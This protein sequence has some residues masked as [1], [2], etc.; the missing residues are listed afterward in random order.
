[1][2]E[3]PE[4][5]LV[6]LQRKDDD[7]ICL[8]ASLGGSDRIGYYCVFRGDKEEVIA[9]IEEV[10]AALKGGEPVR[11]L[12]GKAGNSHESQGGRDES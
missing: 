12:R 3:L 11:D 2:D 8:R 9:C 1:M 7:P 6:V 4:D 10:L 5:P